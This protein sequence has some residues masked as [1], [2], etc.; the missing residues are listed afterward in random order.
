MVSPAPT[1]MNS[2]NPTTGLTSR[3]SVVRLPDR[4]EFDP[5]RQ[6]VARCRGRHHT[7]VEYVEPRA[8]HV[9]EHHVASEPT[10][11]RRVLGRDPA[12]TGGIHR[13][14]QGTDAARRDRVEVA[15]DDVGA[16]AGGCRRQP[17]RTVRSVEPGAARGSRCARCMRTR[18]RR[19]RRRERGWR[20]SVVRSPTIDGGAGSRRCGGSASG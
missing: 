2:A 16:P 5:D 7:R 17:G 11:G 14:G 15:A 4:L 12:Q 8:E 19:R 13:R 10:V 20:S 1:S 6:M 18:R 3:G 9:I